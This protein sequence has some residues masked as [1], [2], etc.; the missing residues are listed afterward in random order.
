[1]KS[2]ISPALAFLYSPF[3]SRC[4]ATSMGISMKTS[5]KGIAASPFWLAEICKS[6]AIFRS[7]LYG[8]MNDVKA[9][10]EESAKSFATYQTRTHQQDLFSLQ[11]R[12]ATT[13]A[14]L[15][16]FSFR[17]FSEKPRSLF[18]PNRTLSP[19]RRYAAKPRCKRFCSS[20]VAMVDLPE[21]ESPVNHIVKPL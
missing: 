10:V 17:S 9:I 21:A 8:E 1:V 7:A 20:A 4:S 5:I 15:L 3:G 16:I 12:L 2:L 11:R 14:I 6:R 19:S 18:S 13:S